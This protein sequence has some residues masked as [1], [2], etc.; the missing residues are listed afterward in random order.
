MW[1]PLLNDR[2]AKTWMNGAFKPS[3]RQQQQNKLSKPFSRNRAFAKRKKSNNLPQ[4]RHRNFPFSALIAVLAGCLFSSLEAILIFYSHFCTTFTTTF[5]MNEFRLKI[6][7]CK[8][9]SKSS[10]SLTALVSSPAAV[11]VTSSSVTTTT[12]IIASGNKQSSII[13]KL[14]TPASNNNNN[15]LRTYNNSSKSNKVFLYYT[16]R[17]PR[18]RIFQ[19]KTKKSPLENSENRS[20]SSSANNIRPT[21]CFS[22]CS[23][24]G[25]N[26]KPRHQVSYA[27]CDTN[28]NNFNCK[29]LLKLID[30]LCNY[31]EVIGGGKTINFI[32]NYKQQQQEKSAIENLEII[33]DTYIYHQNNQL[34]HQVKEKSETAIV[35]VTATHFDSI[36]AI[37]ALERHLAELTVVTYIGYILSFFLT[38]SKQSNNPALKISSRIIAYEKI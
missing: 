6:V 20:S 22:S 17:D 36:Q 8:S 34:N 37:V 28:L 19:E 9:S 11:P 25:S 5:L 3:H 10:A 30:D 14:T 27:R 1:V 32:S 2:L 4:Q 7:Y 35:A 24:S 18:L 31:G 38:T 12:I 21:Q 16:P 26:Y 23:S 29:S 33:C 13:S 15:H